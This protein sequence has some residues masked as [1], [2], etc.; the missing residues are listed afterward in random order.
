M[1]NG[2]KRKGDEGNTA[3]FRTNDRRMFAGGQWFFL[4]RNA[5]PAGPFTSRSEAQHSGIEEVR[6]QI[7]EEMAQQDL[8]HLKNGGFIY[9][10]KDDGLPKQTGWDQVRD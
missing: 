2:R 1:T 4:M 5:N 6:R 7:A 10:K 3:H 9:T 8:D